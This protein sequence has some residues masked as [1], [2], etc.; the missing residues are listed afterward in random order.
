MA[1]YVKVAEKSQIP[2]NSGT[3]VEVEGRRIALF[4]A[5]DGRFYA[6]DDVCTHEEGPLSEGELDG[7]QVECPWHMAT[8]NIKTGE[9]TGPPADEDV[10]AYNVRLNGEDVEVEV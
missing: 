9:C 10:A 6:I 3:C 4:H 2:Q 1:G 5:E 8:F 7:D